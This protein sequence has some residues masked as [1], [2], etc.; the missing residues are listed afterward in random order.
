MSVGKLPVKNFETHLMLFRAPSRR[1][2][3]YVPTVSEALKAQHAKLASKQSCRNS[4]Y[5][6]S[7]QNIKWPVRPVGAHR[8]WNWNWVLKAFSSWKISP[9]LMLQHFSG[10]L[11]VKSSTARSPVEIWHGSCQCCHPFQKDL[12]AFWAHLQMTFF[13][14]LNMVCEF[15]RSLQLQSRYGEHSALW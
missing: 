5:K 11:S 13:Q 4:Y 6:S 9:W 2:A 1:W 8:N 12:D 3:L 7:Y 14:R 10:N 15:G